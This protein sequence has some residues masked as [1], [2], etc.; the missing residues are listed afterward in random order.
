MTKNR[1][2]HRFRRFCYLTACVVAAA[3]AGLYLIFDPAAA[4]AVARAEAATACAASASLER[5][6]YLFQASGCQG[7]HTRVKPKGDLLAGHRRLETPFGD[8]HTPNITPDPTHGIGSWS[9]DDFTQAMRQGRG[10]DGTVY[11]PA[12]PY[13]SY[14]GMSDADLADL[15]EY[16]KSVP[17]VAVPSRDHELMFPFNL[18]LLIWPWR[19]LYF[20]AGRRVADPSK[21]PFWNR[22]A[23]LTNVVG[24]CGECHTPRNL[25]GGLDWDRAYAG[26][27]R[28]PEGKPVPNI[29][30]H[31]KKG[32]GAWSESDIASFLGDGILPDGDFV[33]GAMAEV[34]ENSTST[35]TKH[36]L[37]AIAH[38]LK[39]LPP[40]DG[41]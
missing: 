17:A 26:N 23:Y 3:G 18:R 40:D 11:F 4:Q 37:A 13:A 38:Y 30:P 28:G 15:W 22:G 1:R 27:A 29:T 5:G 16:L 39:T 9:L 35:L 8:F 31:P 25:L 12:F 14:T 6:R 33:G 21:P 41:N 7:C 20:E 10:P 2:K 32:I 36:D 24:H 34:I 19:W